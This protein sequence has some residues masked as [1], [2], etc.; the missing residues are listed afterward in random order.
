MDFHMLNPSLHLWNE[1]D[2]IV[3]Q[4]LF[5]TLLN[6]VSKYFIENFAS[7]LIKEIGLF[8]SLSLSLSLCVCVCVY[9]HVQAL[10]GFRYQDNTGFLEWVWKSSFPFYFIE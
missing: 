8:L 1:T 4:D 5:D 7:R 9:T 2:L 10:T 6:S 3:T